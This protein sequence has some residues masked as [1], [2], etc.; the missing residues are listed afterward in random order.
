MELS[1]LTPKE[2]LVLVGLAKAIVHADQE[3]TQEET[4]LI[5][6]LA[7]KVGTDAWNQ[8]VAEARTELATA[9]QLFDLAREID[10]VEAR[11]A[12][13]QALRRLAESDDLDDVEAEIL[14][15]VAEVWQLGAAAAD[16]DVDDEEDDEDESTFDQDFVLFDID[17][18]D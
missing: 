16:H 8:R 18:E 2:Q 10:R 15:W 1:E 9:D 11:E 7:S 6:D 5:R 12:I 14:A 3:V 4:A 13:H 17:E